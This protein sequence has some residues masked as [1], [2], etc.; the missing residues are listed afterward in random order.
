MTYQRP[1]L[2]TL[3]ARLN[4]SP[5]VMWVVTGP[6]QVGKSTLVRQALAGRPAT[7]IATDNPVSENTDPF[8]GSTNFYQTLPG[9]KPTAQWIVDQ[10]QAARAKA[11]E[12]PPG[13][14]YVLALDEIQ[15]IPRWADIVKGLWDHDRTTEVPLH[16]VLLGSSPWLMQKGLSESLAGR[17]ETIPLTHWSYA[18]MQ[19]AFDFS[20]DEYIFFGAYPGAAKYIR[21]ETRWRHYVLDALIKPTIE[22][23]ILQMTR[24]D[25][26]TLLKNLFELGCGAYS[27]Q[28][29]SLDK[30]TGQLPGAG[31]T[32]TLAHYIELLTRADLLT[33]LQKYAVQAHRKRASP[34]K[35]NAHNN[36]LVSAQG[37]YNFAQAKNDRSYWGRLVESAVGT[38]LIATK[39]TNATV[40]Y[41]REAHDEVDFVVSW[42]DQLLALEVKSGTHF[43][44][45]KGLTVFTDK[46]KEKNAKPLLVGEGG[47]PIA[48]FLLS[49]VEDWLNP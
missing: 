44:A 17:Y 36:A 16:V 31:H 13:Q 39:P 1:Q 45:P 25:K 43:T 26:P 20:L 28:I 7:F 32:V 9:V 40:H 14:N 15:K 41:W 35:F 27:G 19:E 34:P 38:H 2:Q 21:D 37:V 33:G 42:G 5:Q 6:R 29:I 10:W 24:V 46:F 12:L 4:E 30:L 22:L 18:E 48:Q 3:A 49:P 8:G 23:D 11:R 47:T